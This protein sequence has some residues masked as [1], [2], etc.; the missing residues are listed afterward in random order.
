[1][2]VQMAQQD[3]GTATQGIV[4][5]SSGDMETVLLTLHAVETLVRK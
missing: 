5:R 1:M 3:A 2:G 4:S